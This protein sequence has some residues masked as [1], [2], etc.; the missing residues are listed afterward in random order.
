MSTNVLTLS[1]AEFGLEEDVNFN[2]LIT[3]FE[4]GKEQRRNLWTYGVR[5]YNLTL[6]YYS[7]TN[8]D[9]LWDF[10][11]ARKGTYDTFLI[12][13][14]TE[15]TV[16]TEAIGTGDAK[17]TAFNL[18]E[19]PVD[20]TA[21]TF[22][23]YAGGAAAS[24]TLANNFT[25]EISAVTFASAPAAVALTGDYEF[26]F[27]VRFEE[28]R[29]TRKLMQYQLLNTSVKFVEVRWPTQYNPRAGNV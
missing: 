9:T 1:D 24:A 14:Y 25:T 8:M 5:R 4:T 19:F 6:N 12:K 22:T 3:Q 13:V 21:G 18:D 11:I 20:T 7:K 26:Y 28:D 23:M 17:T 16:T 27:Q 10:Y 2:T 15:Y 29:L